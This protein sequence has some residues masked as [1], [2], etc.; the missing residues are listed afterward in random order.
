MEESS[1]IKLNSNGF[2]VAIS[3]HLVIFFT[4]SWY[5]S[6]AVPIQRG[7]FLKPG[8]YNRKHIQLLVEKW[9]MKC[10]YKN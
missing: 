3:K 6:F 7:F 2:V 9:Q 8:L 10:Y 1:K 5:F 4:I